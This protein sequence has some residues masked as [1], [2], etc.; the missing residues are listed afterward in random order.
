MQAHKIIFLFL[1][2]M[3]CCASLENMY[4]IDGNDAATVAASE[5]LDRYVKDHPFSIHNPDSST[6]NTDEATRLAENFIAAV[7][8][9]PANKEAWIAAKKTRRTRC[10]ENQNAPIEAPELENDFLAE[11]SKDLISLILANKDYCTE[12]ISGGKIYIDADK[13]IT[14]PGLNFLRLDE[15]YTLIRLPELYADENGCYLLML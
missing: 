14:L 8:N 10:L 3:A 13:I 11:S 7:E 4:C 2:A 1:P 15:E 5:E 6:F 9:S 12:S